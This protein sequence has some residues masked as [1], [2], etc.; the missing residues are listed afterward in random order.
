VKNSADLP[1]AKVAGALREITEILAREVTVPTSVPPPWSEFEW[2]IA[3]SVAAMQGVSSLLGRNL[4]WP[5]PCSWRR[6]LDAQRDHVA[7]RHLRIAD[8]LD[9]VD[10]Q[11]R[12][13]GIPVVALKGAALHASGIYKAGERPMAD[14]DLLV[15]DGDA[16]AT[17][18]LLEGFDF[19]VTLTSSRHQLFEPRLRK[20]HRATRF[21]EDADNPIKIELH[22]SIRERFP[23][24]ETDITRFVFPRA[25]RSGLNPYPS[26]VSLM[27]HLLLHAAGNVRVHSLRLIQLEDIARVAGRFAPRDWDELLAAR[28]SSRGLWW[29]VPPL[30]LTARYFPTA[31]P[32][33][34]ILQLVS[35]CPWLL[36]RISRKQ[37]LADVSWSNIKVQALPGIEWS[38]SPQEALRFMIARIWPSREIRGELHRFAAHLPGG[39]EIPWYGISQGARILRWVFTNPPRVHTLLTVRAAFTETINE[40]SCIDDP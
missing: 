32:P 5:H 35:E 17:R 40:S 23:L 14:V 11:A 9:R 24:N 10:S 27:M 25:A 20:F 34:I 29:A 37:R 39:S 28:P 38:R 6:F 22:T 16:K 15:L 21:G 33:S 36:R 8:L 18:L 7:R 4:R 2:R 31:I 3:R 13:S 1:L 26:L 12:S 30:M 19:E